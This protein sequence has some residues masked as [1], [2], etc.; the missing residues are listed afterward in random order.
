LICFS[1]SFRCRP[2]FLLSERQEAELVQQKTAL[3]NR[4]RILNEEAETHR[5]QA[6]RMNK[7]IEF[8]EERAA[9]SSSTTSR[10]ISELTDDI[11]QLQTALQTERRQYEDCKRQFEEVQRAL[12]A[13][14]QK[15]QV[16]SE[17]IYGSIHDCLPLHPYSPRSLFLQSVEELLIDA[18]THLQDRTS[19][20][21]L[22]G[23]VH[24]HG[25]SQLIALTTVSQKGRLQI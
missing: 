13:S 9:E 8:L 18:N 6:A 3:E 22:H 14:E 23:I 2:L 21:A 20:V 17:L 7:R 10:Q 15:K 19:T 24:S 4:I 25:M 16:R 11:Q 5:L 1:P 12:D